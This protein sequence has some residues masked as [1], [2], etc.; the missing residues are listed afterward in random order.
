M[1]LLLASDLHYVPN[2][3]DEIAL[4]QHRLPA[5]TYNHQVDGK[6]FWHNQMLVESG[7][8]LLDGLER[9]T[10]Q[11]EADRLIFL[12]DMVNIN[13]E[14]SVAAV[15]ARFANFPCPVRQVTGNHD[16]YLRGAENRLQDA[17]TPGT[18][19]TGFRHETVEGLGLIYL[20]LFATHDLVA[21]H[22]LFVTDGQGDYHKW[23][24][25]RAAVRIDYRPE[26]MVAAFEEM[27]AEPEKPWLIFGHFPFVSPDARIDLA[28]RKMGRLWPS[29]SA[30]ADHLQQ[31]NNLLGI[32]CGHQHFAHYQSFRHGFHWTLPA[33][34]EY[35]CSAAIIEWDGERLQGRIVAV[36][37]ELAATSLRPRQESWTAGEA[38]DRQF[39]WPPVG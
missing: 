10:R 19:P 23:L 22:D 26:D 37:P 27:A 28:G 38:A 1:K 30:L 12:G 2:L 3:A 24:D 5:G 6:L 14:K 9:I 13:W 20:D 35:P 15:G 16:I 31:P 32:L 21:T 11:E 36:D 33:L 29:T 7:E 34:V 18:Y 25:P 4:N 17:V 8:Q 39:T